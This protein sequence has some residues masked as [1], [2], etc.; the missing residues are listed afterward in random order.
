MLE[1]GYIRLHRQLM[2]WRW[3]QDSHV[4]H[5]W[6]HILLTA[7]YEPRGWRDI[8]V[9]RGQL[10]TSIAGLSEQTGLSVKAVRNALDKLKKT[11]EVTVQSTRQYTLVTVNN[12]SLYQ[13]DCASVPTMD[14]ASEGQTKGKPRANQ[15]QTKG[16]NGKKKKI[17][18]LKNNIPPVPPAEIPFTGILGDAVR[19][20]MTYKA[21]RGEDYQPT[22]LRSLLTQIENKAAA[23]GDAAVAECIRTSMANGW[24]GII[25]DRMQQPD[26]SRSSGGSFADVAGDW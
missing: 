4:L 5:L 9:E 11:G 7:N 20:W 26:P 10:V 17:K 16:N 6:M 3:Y 22:G 21:E 19:D 15:G 18:K 14:G 12:Y 23:H 25:W 13:S 8:T 24:R 2:A 1:G